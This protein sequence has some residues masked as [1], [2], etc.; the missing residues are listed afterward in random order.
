M[1]RD[2][3][4]VLM[5]TRS[6]IVLDGGLATELERDG[7]DLDDPLWSAKV[8]VED[9]DA[10]RDVHFD[11][12]DAGADCITTASY[13][14]SVPGFLDFG[15][16]DRGANELILRSVEI[17]EEARA[18]FLEERAA[19]GEE[20]SGAL[21]E[22]WI[23][24]SI[25]P[26][27][28][29]LADGSEFTGRYGVNRKTLLDFHRDRLGLLA[30]SAADLLA[31]ETVPS[32][33]EAGVLLEL[34]RDHNDSYA[35][36]SFSCKDGAHL[37]DGTP[38]REIAREC[39]I[40]QQIAAVGVNCTAPKFVSPLIAELRR[41]TRK[42]IIVYPNSGETFSIEER[43][44]TGSSDRIAF[45]DSAI[46]WLEEGAAA[47]GGCC[48]VGTEDIAEIRAAFDNRG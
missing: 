8:L 1:K 33:E 28:A 26:Y 17:A 7:F 41:A 10:I 20:A 22:P 42:P 43:G 11:Y 47:V 46:R 15:L 34:L 30:T 19:D 16:R 32:A 4:D 18:E 45:G 23:A 5:E 6:G 27:G 36:I 38:I 2:L 40:S 37:N 24:A 31:C 3:L 21:S 14:A 13:Q 12:L 44:W 29:Y 35:W 39:D 9:P 25:G 48:R